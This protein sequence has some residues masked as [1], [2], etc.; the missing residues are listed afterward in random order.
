[1]LSDGYFQ[2]DE[3]LNISSLRRHAYRG[4]HKNRAEIML[5]MVFYMYLTG[6]SL[7]NPLP[8]NFSTT[9]FGSLL[10]IV[11]YTRTT[12]KKTSFQKK[13][14]SRRVMSIEMEKA[15]ERREKLTNLM[16]RVVTYNLQHL[17][18]VPLPGNLL[19]VVVN[20]LL[21]DIG[22]M[23]WEEDCKWE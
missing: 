4:N 1:M 21:L 6:N 14:M 9:T 23:S 2:I 7:K 10:N 18:K 17:Q 15:P 12:G 20:Y 16:T 3:M 22:L 13:W 5:Y 19:G 11:S 8:K